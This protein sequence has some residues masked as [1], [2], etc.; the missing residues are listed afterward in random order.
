MDGAWALNTVWNID[1]HRRLPALAWGRDK[2]FYWQGADQL[3]VKQWRVLVPPGS[4][5]EDDQLIL[6]LRGTQGNGRPDVQL[7]QEIDLLLADDPS[8]YKAAIGKRLE[9]L[10]QSLSGWVLP[11]FFATADGNP[12]PIMISFDP[13]CEHLRVRD[14]GDQL[15]GLSI[16]RRN[17]LNST[18]E[19]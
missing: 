12:P 1:K 2:L 11:R 8:P 5:L 10:H 18:C 15:T 4:F 6:E 17:G 13:P 3:S 7:T 9:Q 19:P 16:P 14:E